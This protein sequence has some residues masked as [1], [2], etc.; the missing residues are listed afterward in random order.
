MTKD[1]KKKKRMGRPPK[2]ATK[3]YSE[4][5]CIKMT[6]AERAMLAREAKKRGI[7]VSALLMLQWRKGG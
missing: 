1:R 4:I 5:V 3:K 7:T 2:P 6:K